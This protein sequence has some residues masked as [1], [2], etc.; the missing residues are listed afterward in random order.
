MRRTAYDKTIRRKGKNMIFRLQKRLLFL[1]PL[2]CLVLS[3]L[4]PKE[5]MAGATQGVQLILSGAL[6]ALFPAL[7]L[8]RVIALS[9]PQ[10]SPKL[11]RFLPLILALLCG[12]PIGALTAAHLSKT[13]AISQKEAERDLFSC[14]LVGPSFLIGVAGVGLMHSARA[15]LFLYLAQTAFAILSFFLLHRSLPRPKMSHRPRAEDSS[16]SF[17]AVFSQSLRESIGA[18][19]VICGSIV[20]FSFLA[21]LL[22]AIV[23]WRDAPAA[24]ITLFLELTSGV[25]ALT[26]IAREHA[27]LFL[28]A[29]CGWGSC[30]V[31]LQTLSV[32]RPAGLSPKL[33]FAGRVVESLF[34]LGIVKI[35]DWF[36]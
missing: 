21:S 26:K 9:F 4:F 32:I 19:G 28:S 18:F 23:S 10:N 22:Q 14:G 17:S 25:H 29:G 35:L 7:F 13:G 1:L 3:F 31:H 11:M 34:L 33:Y 20:F 6:P 12:A 27:F 15:G 2:L 16:L 8:C 24:A 36:L 5:A 30:S